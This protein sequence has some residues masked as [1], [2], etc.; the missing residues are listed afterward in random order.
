MCVSPIQLPS[1]VMVKCNC[2]R[3]CMG[4]RVNDW[5]GRCVAEQQTSS[6]IMA[7][8]L[9]YAQL[10]GD[11]LDEL[12]GDV[13]RM[14]K[15]LRSD[16]FSVRYLCCGEYGSLK[17]RPHWHI[18]LFFRGN[19][20]EV[21][22]DTK[23]YNWKYWKHGYTYVQSPD[24]AGMSYVL[25][26]T[27]KYEDTEGAHNSKRIYMSKKPPIGYHYFQSLARDYV[28]AGLPL[29]SPEYRFAHL[30]LR[31]GK[32][33]TFWLADRSRELF[34]DGYVTKW[35]ETYGTEPQQ[36]DFLIEEYYD[37]IAAAEVDEERWRSKTAPTGL[38]YLLFPYPVLGCMVKYS[39][40]SCVYVPH[41]LG[42]DEKPWR[43]HI[44]DGSSSAVR[45]AAAILY[46]SG[47]RSDLVKSAIRWITRGDTFQ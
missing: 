38:G 32:L 19:A 13:Q 41:N 21:E 27:L 39:D 35:R 30:R 9:T 44:G 11:V 34:V 7:L 22:Y 1:G 18:I 36:T 43:I 25:K 20:P 6:H 8:T 29:V 12:Y 37:P 2:C 33:R 4:N 45:R 3:W 24:F 40:G 26:Y 47:L 5:A 14:L 15:R 16:G 17:R 46:K 28:N 31:S 42:K 10:H 23:Y